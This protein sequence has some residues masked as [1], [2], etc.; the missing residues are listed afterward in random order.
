MPGVPLQGENTQEEDREFLAWLAGFWEGEGTI[1]I[2]KKESRSRKAPI[3]CAHS[4]CLAIYL[5]ISQTDRLPLDLIQSRLGTGKIFVQEHNNPR[6]KTTFVWVV[7]RKLDILKVLRLIFPFLKFKHEKVRNAI[8]H[9]EESRY[10]R[11]TT[12][13]GEFL[14]SSSNK[15]YC[16]NCFREHMLEYHRQYRRRRMN[17]DPSYAEKWRKY[18][19][20]YN[21][22]PE[23]REYR[24]MWMREYNA[25]PEVKENKRRWN[26]EYRKRQK[27]KSI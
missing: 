11:C 5:A 8:I 20:E 24:R 15:R 4:G 16:E 23:C 22:R 14:K 25:R 6:H 10:F 18:A 1:S 27:A 9:L 2:R 17:E 3:A 21:K 19:L 13:G 12:C 26:Q 7:S